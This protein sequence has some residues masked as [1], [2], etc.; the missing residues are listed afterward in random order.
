M[1][2]EHVYSGSFNIEAFRI[3]DGGRVWWYGDGTDPVTIRASARPF[4]RPTVSNGVVYA[5]ESLGALVA[6]RADN[7]DLLWEADLRGESLSLANPPVIGEKYI[8]VAVDGH[9]KIKAVDPRTRKFVRTF[10]MSG[11]F[12][13]AFVAHHRAGKLIWT[14]GGFV[15]A[16]PLE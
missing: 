9:S 11:E 1:D 6:L 15:C 10:T 7:G 8:Y 4:S 5:F 3:S 2:K 14:S 16:V 13:R 12:D